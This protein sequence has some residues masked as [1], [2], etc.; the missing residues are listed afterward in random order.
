MPEPIPPLLHLA[1]LIDAKETKL[2]RT[3]TPFIRRQLMTD[4]DS[5]VRRF[6]VE[7]QLCHGTHVPTDAA[8]A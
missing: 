2:E 7:Y 1:S 4:L 5:L 6:Q 8:L 3:M